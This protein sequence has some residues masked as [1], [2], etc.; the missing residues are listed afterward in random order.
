VED[1][2]MKANNKGE[3]LLKKEVEGEGSGIPGNLQLTRVTA[4]ASAS[5]PPF[6]Y[7]SNETL[8]RLLDSENENFGRIPDWVRDLYK[9]DRGQG[10]GE[11]GAEK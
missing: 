5:F 1:L 4:R 2:F 8:S 7:L 6:T 11:E 3:S 10:E 9:G